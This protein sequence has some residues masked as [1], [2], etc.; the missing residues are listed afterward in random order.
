M[1]WR[2]EVVVGTGASE[3]IAAAVMALADPRTKIALFGPTS[4]C[5]RP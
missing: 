2:D 5:I 1:D 4:T 3:V